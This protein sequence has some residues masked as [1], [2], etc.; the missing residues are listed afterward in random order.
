M[1]IELKQ[2]YVAFLDILGFSEMVVS[3]VMNEKQ[4]NLI[5][6]FRCHQGAANIFKDD[7]YCTVTQFSDSIVVAK[8]YDAKGFSW[9]VTKIAEYQRLLLDEGLLCRGG[10]V[11]NK[12]FS[13]G[14]FTFSAGIIDAY[15]VESTIARY[16]RVVISRDLIDLIFPDQQEYPDFLIKEDD[17]LVFVDYIGLFKDQKIEILTTS[18]HN[19]VNVLTAS[20]IPSLKEKGGWLSNYSDAVLGTDLASPKFTGGSIKAAK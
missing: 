1:V 7:P 3:D 14:S 10:I 8:P 20:K 18:I 17:G 13:N 5:K 15:L 6:L 4:L 16:P 9:F 11:V 2:H 12:H 19:I